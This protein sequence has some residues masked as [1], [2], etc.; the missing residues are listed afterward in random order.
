MQ[1][2]VKRGAGWQIGWKPHSTQFKGLVGSDDWAVELTELELEHFCHLLTQLVETIR[3]LTSE[4]MDEEKI[5]CEAETDLVWME[6][7]GYAHLYSMRFIL[8]NGR[9]VQGYLSAHAV[10]EL[11]EAVATLKVF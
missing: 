2:V 1:K 10:Q 9:S 11:V 5:T 4:L 6:V 3:V 8:T 7:E